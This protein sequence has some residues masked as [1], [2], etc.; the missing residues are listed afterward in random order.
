MSGKRGLVMN[1]VR[2][3]SAVQGNAVGR[4]GGGHHTWMA[5]R[6]VVLRISVE[7]GIRPESPSLAIIRV[8]RQNFVD[9]DSD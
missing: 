9:F 6:T 4:G 1:D 2:S 5:D 3:G 8:S 7:I